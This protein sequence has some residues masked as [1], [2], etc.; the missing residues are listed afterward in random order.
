MAYKR[1]NF[2]TSLQKFQKAR[3]RKEIENESARERKS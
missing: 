2:N 1:M 3:V